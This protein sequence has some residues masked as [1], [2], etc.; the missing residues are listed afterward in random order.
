MRRAAIGLGLL[1]PLALAGCMVSSHSVEQEYGVPVGPATLE[2]IPQGDSGAAWITAVLGPPDAIS[3]LEEP[4]GAEAW[5]WWSGHRERGSSA[6][7]IIGGRTSRDDQVRTEVIVR[8]GVVLEASQQRQSGSIGDL[9][10]PGTEGEPGGEAGG[11]AGDAADE[12]VGD[13]AGDQAGGG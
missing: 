3:T 2:R 7:L 9:P 13:Q 12:P 6:V 1:G 11:E 4:P 8:D 5:T 10:V